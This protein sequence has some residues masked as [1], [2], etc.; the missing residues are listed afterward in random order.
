M[1]LSL[2]FL[3]LLFIQLP[4]F[5]SAAPWIVTADYQ[6]VV[7]TRTYYYDEETLTNTQI[8]Q[9][10]PTATSLPQALS[11]ITST[12]TSGYY[13]EDVTII[14]R[15]YPTGVGSYNDDDYGYGYGDDDDEYHTTIFVVNIT[16][17]A[18]TG[19][20]S[21][22]TQ[23]T[24]AEVDPPSEVE[25]LLPRTAVATSISVDNSQP[26]QPTSYTIDIVY[27]DPTQLPSRSLA[28]LSLYNRP[29]S[30]YTGAGCTYTGSDSADADSG[31]SGYYNG[32]GYGYGSGYYY[33]DDDDNWFTDPYYLGISYLA[34]TL[35]TLFGWIGLFLIFGF[36]EAWVRF[37]RLMMG[38]QTRRG[39]PF[40]WSL[41][42]LPISLLLLCFWRKG[43]RARSQA[44]GEVLKKRWNAMG[45][46]TKLRLFFVWGFRFKYP[47]MLGP[48]PA[49]VKTS[50]Q[51]EKNPGPR[52][53]ESTP[54]PSVAPQSRQ[55]SSDAPAAAAATTTDP[56]MAEVSPATAPVAHQPEEV[57]TTAPA[58]HQSEEAT[59]AAPT[60]S[61]ALPSPHHDEEAGRAN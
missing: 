17:T 55:G 15:L 28:S 48:A 34:I 31:S 29:T 44:D 7:Y 59:A 9:I 2:S 37:R 40:C 14:Q 5:V 21:Q 20:S 51:P 23:T 4:S 33:G 36:I 8:E 13:D 3:L 1:A 39:L 10:T 30:L 56:E 32:N 52:L 50:K 16:Y 49:R 27:V 47:P 42:L 46:G 35:I 41:T 45:F 6:E 24:T 25:D 18:P 61:G 38:W 22:W 54:T 60:A 43:Y 57:A 19:C 11:T 58:A 53:L 12:G 26:F